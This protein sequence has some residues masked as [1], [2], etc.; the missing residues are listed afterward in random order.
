MRKGRV[1][2]GILVILILAAGA[3]AFIERQPLIA[4][5]HTVQESVKGAK[6]QAG[7]KGLYYCPMHPSFTSDR[8]GNCAICGMNLVKKT[9]ADVPAGG[10]ESG[11]GGTKVLYYRNPMN[12]QVTSL[13]PMKDQMGMDYVPVYGEQTPQ[14]HPGV[15]I[16]PEKQ[17]LIG[18]KKGKVQIRK[19]SGQI[20][21]VG[22]VAY[23]PDLFVA[24]QEYLQTQKG[25]ASTQKANLDYLD[26]QSQSLL[27]AM[28]HKLL[29][30]GMSN[31]EIDEMEKRGT[32]ETGLYLPSPEDKSIWVY[33]MIY[34]YEAGLV[35]EGLAVQVDAL[36][37]PGQTFQ[38]RIVAIAPL[39]EAATR[40]LKARA[41]VDNTDGKL[42]AEMFVNA[43]IDY[44][45]GEK[46]AVPEDAV[47][48]AGT[49][50]IAFVV[51]PNG[52]FES[53][54]VL[55]GAK[56]Q[57]YYEVLQGLAANEEVVTSANFLVDS[58]SKLNAVLSRTTE[59]NQPPSQPHGGRP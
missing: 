27:K 53:K 24:Q 40:T 58:E 54:M 30:L 26:E 52:Y 45:L 5:Y 20:R 31:A 46:L 37:Y 38:G 59:P 56:A 18:V 3:V 47:M 8:P 15:Y 50:D 17:Q 12:P 6:G 34:E 22:R 11:Q 51:D 35:K 28:R 14:A 10:Q 19:L 16:S 25:R 13:V 39:L 43:R 48:H 33:I 23:D 32:P 4:W 41:L 44:E 29:L 55:L 57:G 49:R 9:A 7:E 1:L 42:K 21:T 36:A 2:A